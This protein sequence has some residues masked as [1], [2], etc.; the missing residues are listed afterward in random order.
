[1]VLIKLV[2]VHIYTL[3]VQT[4]SM[5]SLLN[6]RTIFQTNQSLLA[7]FSKAICSLVTRMEPK[8]M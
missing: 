3:Y 5:L 7:N 6:S 1:M 8:C 4:F 2:K